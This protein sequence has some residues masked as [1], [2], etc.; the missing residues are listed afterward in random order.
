[1]AFITLF[2]TG[3][4]PK[5]YELNKPR[6]VVGR[7]S[8]CDVHI[9]NLAISK[10]HCEFVHEGDAFILRDLNS[11]NKTFMNGEEIK[12]HKLKDGEEAILGP[13]RLKFTNPQNAAPKS[14]DIP[15]ASDGFEPTLQLPPD[16][17]RKKIAEMQAEKASSAH[18]NEAVKVMTAKDYA[19][20]AS[21]PAPA[22][23]KKANMVATIFILAIVLVVVANVLI[24]IVFK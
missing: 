22:D 23:A 9:D 2:T 8:R 6:I 5:T 13:Y 3:A 1:M 15:T 24:F 18:S 21:P 11:S 16:M 7:D 17:I 14:A 10:Q 20:Q 12:E 19:A 4:E